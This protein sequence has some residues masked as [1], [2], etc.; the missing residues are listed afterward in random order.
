LLKKDCERASSVFP[1]KKFCN[2]ARTCGSRKWAMRKFGVKF[3]GNRHRGYDDAKNGARLFV[4]AL[5]SGRR[6]RFWNV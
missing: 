3:E 4:A 1:F 2:I 6:H 5:N